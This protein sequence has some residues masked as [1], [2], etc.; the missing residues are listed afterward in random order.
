MAWLQVMQE[1]TGPDPLPWEPSRISGADKRRV[2]VFYGTLLTLLERD[3]INRPSMSGVC[4]ACNRLL[5]ST[6]THDG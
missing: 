1:I 4:S 5:S 2:G 6:T 3:P